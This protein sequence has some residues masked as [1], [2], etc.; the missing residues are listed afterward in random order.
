MTHGAINASW[1]SPAI[2]VC[3]P[4]LPKGAS[5]V[6]RSPRLALPHKRVRF[7]FTAVSSIKTTR[8]G[9]AETAGSRYLNQSDR[10]CLTLAR[11]RSVA[12]SDF[13]CM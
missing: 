13:F 8:S 11:Q 9:R 5:I 3:V 12:T 1:V 4:Q 7:V 6:S 2:N 10:C